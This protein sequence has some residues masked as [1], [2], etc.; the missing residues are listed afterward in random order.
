[1]CSDP[2]PGSDTDLFPRLLRGCR[3]L[4]PNAASRV[5]VD[6]LGTAARVDVQERRAAALTLLPPPPHFMYLTGLA[7]G[8]VDPTSSSGS[9][10]SLL[11]SVDLDLA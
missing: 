6:P 1:M 5:R 10:P 3:S 7:G 8:L 4:S 11:V 2:F 9:Y